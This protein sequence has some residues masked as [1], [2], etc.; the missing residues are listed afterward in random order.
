MAS[1]GFVG[2][3]VMGGELVN[4]LISKGHTVTGYNR[5]KSK[6]EWLIK[7]GMK[8]ADSP[9]AVTTSADIV[10]SVV[11]NSAALEAI[12]EGPEG[13]LAGLRS[14]K[15]YVDISTVSPDYSRV[16]AEKVRAKGADMLDS[17]VSGSVITLQE[18]K[19]SVMVGG[20]KETF[21]K[22]KPILLD[23]GPKVTYVGG[24]GQALVLKIA[25][26]L[27]LAVQMLSFSE[28]VLLAEKSGIS[29]EIAVDVLT[30]SAIASPMVKYRGPFVI[31]LPE[32]AWF[33]VNMMQKDMLLALELGRKLDVP[34]PSTAVANEVLTAA[35]GVGLEKEDFAV[36]FDVLAQLCG[37]KR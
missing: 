34:M 6:A 33:N 5:T 23:I 24:N 31:K 7:A 28:G 30:N 37:V 36:V 32:E 11:T 21:E 17:P 25:S 1:L 19:L 27:S 22:V 29:R 14:G 9:R 3:G 13:I 8:W 12:I 2:L 16:V 10:F 4:R 15:I 18:G 26:N 35:R 20:R